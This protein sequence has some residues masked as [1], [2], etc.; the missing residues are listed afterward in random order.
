MTDRWI[1][2]RYVCI[3][4]LLEILTVNFPSRTIRTPII[5][6]SSH[7]D[8]LARG[9]LWSE[10]KLPAECTLTFTSKRV[11]K[12]IPHLPRQRFFVGHRSSS[13]F[14]RSSETTTETRTRGVLG[15]RI[16]SVPGTSG[17]GFNHLKSSFKA[18][19]LAVVL[20]KEKQ[21]NGQVVE[22]AYDRLSFA[23]YLIP[24]KSKINRAD[25]NSWFGEEV[26]I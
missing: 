20:P 17:T 16:D 23:S 24:G 8:R 15:N 7:K 14:V 26:M 5:L 25:N 1:L 13:G 6:A 21:S 2:Y 22:F 11:H 18:I 12:S 9:A 19:S 3:L 10:V 4:S